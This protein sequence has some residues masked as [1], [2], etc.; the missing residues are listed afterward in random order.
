MLCGDVVLF[1]GDVLCDDVV[2]C[3]DIVLLCSEAKFC[4]DVL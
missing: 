4:G 3:G 1:C 2:L